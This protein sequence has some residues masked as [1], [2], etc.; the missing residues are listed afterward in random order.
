LKNSFEILVAI[1]L[2]LLAHAQD[3]MV[4][5]GN[6]KACAL[7]HMRVRVLPLKFLHFF[8]FLYAVVK[9]QHAHK[10]RTATAGSWFFPD[11]GKPHLGALSSPLFHS[12]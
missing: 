11:H 7:V 1:L 2:I 4:S 3:P 5:H 12:W 6:P 10:A 8:A 9:V